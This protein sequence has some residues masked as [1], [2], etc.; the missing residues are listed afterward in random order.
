MRYETGQESQGIL[1]E[2]KFCPPILT[3]GVLVGDEQAGVIERH[4]DDDQAAQRIHGE[5]PRTAT[6]DA[7]CGLN[8]AHA[9]LITMGYLAIFVPN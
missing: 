1:V 9:V 3:R 7:F 2:G 6:V 8:V 4:E 5:Q